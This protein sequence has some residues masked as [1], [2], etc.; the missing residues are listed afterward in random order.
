[1]GIATVMFKGSNGAGA[2]SLTTSHW[3]FGRI[4]ARV[5]HVQQIFEDI[6]EGTVVLADRSDQFEPLLTLGGSI[7]QNASN[8]W[9]DALFLACIET[10]G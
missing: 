4:P 9:T 1:M 8:D 5:I 2:I 3:S 6:S 10:Q 7:Q